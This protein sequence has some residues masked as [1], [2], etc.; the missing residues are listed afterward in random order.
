MVLWSNA[1]GKSLFILIWFALFEGYNLQM[2]ASE[3]QTYSGDIAFTVGSFGLLQNGD[4][5]VK[6]V[7]LDWINNDFILDINSSGPEG[8]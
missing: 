7:D 8:A 3:V 6:A 2:I 5:A 4:R 1:S